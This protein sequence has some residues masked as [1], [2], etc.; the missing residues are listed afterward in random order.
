MKWFINDGKKVIPGLMMML[1]MGSVYSYSVFRLPIESYYQLSAAQSG[2]PYMLS[3]FFY[4]VF[5][6]I[7]GKI[8]ERIH[9]FKVMV[10]GVLFVALGWLVSYFAN[11]LF[12]LSLGYGVFIGTGIGLIYGIPLM[13]ITN[14]FEKNKGLY[15]GLILLGFGLSPLITA[16]LLQS[17]V[18]NHGLH[19]T[20]LYMSAL[21]LIILLVLSFFYIKDQPKE[22]KH[23][24]A[25][26][27]ETV[28]T[29]T[30]KLLYLQFFIATLIG[31][32]IIGF[33]STYAVTE[34][35]ITFENA[36]LFV[37]AFALFNGL[38]RV[39]YGFLADRYDITKLM[40]FSYVSLF[41]ASA[42][43]IVFSDNIVAFS[44]SFS[45]FW[46]NLG[47]WLAIA[48]VA[49]SHFFGNESYAK[50]YGVLFSAYG[51]SAL[52]GVVISGLL[53]DLFDGYQMIFIFFLLLAMIG[54]FLSHCLHKHMHIE[55]Q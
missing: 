49:T 51:L 10:A 26:I 15:L 35:N 38:G 53:Y 42:L 22:K 39:L 25:H 46:V 6:G 27:M 30:F 43:M 1:V 7:S 12:V 5:M 8:L 24:S 45:I 28:K 31:L 16:P 20:F 50:N 29:K 18:E 33:S 44:I 13:I 41:L 9:L 40:S 19:M 55:N 52:F 34:L 17:L 3:L 47:G 32:S 37:S 21:S 11:S 23:V 14:Q 2:V 4:A 48:P 36:A 54:L